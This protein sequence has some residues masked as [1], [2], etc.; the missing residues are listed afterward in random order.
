MNLV[1]ENKIAGDNTP[2]KGRVLAEKLLKRVIAQEFIV[3]RFTREHRSQD[4]VLL[5]E[6]RWIELAQVHFMLVKPDPRGLDMGFRVRR[7]RV[8][9]RDRTGRRALA[10]DKAIRARARRP[11]F[12]KRCIGGTLGLTTNADRA[13]KAL[14]AA[15]TSQ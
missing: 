15:A 6:P 3:A 8:A 11:A 13:S 9:G 10:F 7:K 1:I 14:Y 4:R 2:K 5:I 12:T